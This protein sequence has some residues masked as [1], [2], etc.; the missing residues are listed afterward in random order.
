LQ[1]LHSEEAVE[2]HQAKRRKITQNGRG[3]PADREEPSPVY[4]DDAAPE[5]QTEEVNEPPE[6]E[7]DDVEDVED[8]SDP[9]EVHFAT[10]EQRLTSALTA[11]KAGRWLHQPLNFNPSGRLRLSRPDDGDTAETSP[12]PPLTSPDQLKL[13]KRL[14]EPCQKVFS[15]IDGLIKSLAPYVLRYQDLLFAARSVQNASSLRR[16]TALHILNHVFKTRDR[17]I[18]NNTR[19]SRDQDGEEIDARDQGFARPKVLVL[20]ETRQHCFKMVTSLMEFAQPEQQENKKRFE[21]SFFEPETKFSDDRPADFRE[22]FDG[23]DD[24]EFRLGI[25]FTRKTV[26]LFSPFYASDIILASPL[27]LRRAVEQSELVFL[28][29]LIAQS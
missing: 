4:D 3:E 27:G 7:V 29:N 16:L 9:F 17:I 6:T 28:H 13:K 8:A 26:K 10:P 20:L 5:S 22:L 19:I 21:E 23:N 14:V 2:R 11:A 15:Q 12:L 25:K 24:N 18:K 1:S